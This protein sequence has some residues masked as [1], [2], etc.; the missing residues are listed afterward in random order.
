MILRWG[1]GGGGHFQYCGW[2]G[3]SDDFKM[4]W[5]GGNF[6]QFWMRGGQFL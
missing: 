3:T 5:G 2:G 1:G 6:Q 4:G